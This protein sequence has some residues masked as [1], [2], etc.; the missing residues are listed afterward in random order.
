[1][2]HQPALKALGNARKELFRTFCLPSM[3]HQTSKNFFWL[4]YTDP[5]LDR[6]I[7]DEMAQLL[8]P[9]PY[10]YLVS[11]LEDR[12]CFAGTDIKSGLSPHDFK[13]GNTT[14]LFDQIAN[15]NYPTVLE[16]R[17]D[18][19]DAININWI[20]EVQRRA[21]QV[22]EVKK[23]RDWMYWCI[24]RAMEWNWVGPGDRK[25]L[26]KYG[27]L[28]QARP[29]DER[30][31]CHTPGMTVGVRKWSRIKSI[32]DAP[33]HLLYEELSTKN[34]PCGPRHSGTECITFIKNFTFAALRSRTPT[35]ASMSSV[36]TNGGKAYRL[37]AAEAVDRWKDAIQMFAFF[38]NNTERI[39]SYF[40]DNMKAIL[41][42]NMKGQCTKGH[43]CRDE[44]KATLERMIQ[45][46]SLSDTNNN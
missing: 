46:Y 41:V 1:M 32:K 13:T 36:S 33:H 5:L 39:S 15:A 24:N 8:K 21:V 34:S 37:A 27:A 4:I 20:E 35:S 43:S 28:I 10:F 17:L 6:A 26:Q 2:Q 25:P 12:R 9:F 30:N 42:D 22:F 38:P 40:F 31:F 19:D 7:V 14:R 44:A 16:S 45:L 3:V 11:S 18:A 29:Y 23:G